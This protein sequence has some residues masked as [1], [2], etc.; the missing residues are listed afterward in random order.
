MSSLSTAYITP[1]LI[2]Q[3]KIHFP[4]LLSRQGW[5]RS[6]AQRA[7][8]WALQNAR[9]ALLLY[10]C[11]DLPA[12]PRA[13]I[14]GLE[15]SMLPLQESDFDGIAS[16][17]KKAVEL[18][19]KVMVRDLPQNGQ[20]VDFQAYET[21]PLQHISLIKSSPNETKGMDR[22]RWFGDQEDRVYARKWFV[23]SRQPQKTAIV[24]QI[25]SFKKLDHPN[26]AKIFSS[27]SR[28]TIVSLVTIS[29]QS[30]LEDFLHG[31]PNAER[32]RLLLDWIN[33]MTQALAYMHAMDVS[34]KSI[35]PDK[36]LIKDNRIYIS[37]FGINTDSDNRSALP[38]GSDQC[39]YAAPE[40][41]TRHKLGRQADVFS[42][43]RVFLDMLC[44]TRGYTLA[45]LQSSL[46]PPSSP[47]FA[48]SSNRTAGLNN[49]LSRLAAWLKQERNA[50]PDVGAAAP[51]HQRE[52]AALEKAAFALTRDMLAADPSCR[53]KMRL[54]APQVAKRWDEA[55]TIQRR[56]SFDGVEKGARWAELSSLE[57][58][59]SGR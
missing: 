17:P 34:H 25:Q 16:D 18:Q 7:Y 15:D 3:V 59:Y 46:G 1:A 44:V 6:T 45:S 56:R 8:G 10:L 11:D 30:S 50:M 42:L 35:R 52:R 48:A 40:T 27:Y 47:T 51:P 13:V 20:H 21:V 57:G 4:S 49:Y 32:S 26:I 53:P 5:E 36:F 54:R 9:M 28:G 2:S 24:N 12:W 58:Y 14:F 22:V 29:A 33:D 31:P 19:W 55:R 39:T 23:A 38:S 43:G 41:L 37:V